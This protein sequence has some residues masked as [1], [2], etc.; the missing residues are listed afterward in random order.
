MMRLMAPP[1]PA[2]QRGVAMMLVMGA[3]TI[4]FVIAMNVL[5]GLPAT[6]QAAKNL[7]HRDSAVYLAE[8]G[9]VEALTRLA[10]PPQT[11]D[12]TGVTGRTISGMAGTYDVAITDM[13]DGVYQITS[14]GHAVGSGGG[15]VT[16]TLTMTVQVAT[17]GGGGNV[18]TM[19]HGALFGVGGFI[20]GGA[21]VRGDVF[22]PGN[23]L[24]FG[25]VD[26]ELSATGSV[27]DFGRTDS[28]SA[29]AEDVE[30]PS[31]DADLYVSY[32]YN[33]STQNA[34]T[35]TSNAASNYSGKYT[36][37]TDGN[38]L[39]VVIVEG[40]MT[41]SNDVTL[42]GGILIVRG[43]LDL[44]GHRLRINGP[45]DSTQVALI[46]EGDTE[47]S[48]RHSELEVDGG[49]TYLEGSIT[50]GWTARNSKLDARQ[51]LIVK[52]GMPLAFNGDIDVRWDN[53]GGAG[54]DVN[55]FGEGGSSGSGGSGGSRTVT[56]LSY[57]VNPGS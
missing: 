35:V 23:V 19:K 45:S 47:F 36:P 52:Q 42:E 32:T 29:R 48:S 56:P 40:D 21:R 30:V 46:V 12:W 11:G 22:V 26:G 3:V 38:A 25:R 54:T 15:A 50:S 1:R 2:A 55:F 8:S 43:N 5:S 57:S 33:G 16:H 53:N 31:I 28:I 13:G 24:N 18:Y 51:G 9:I 17:G 37:N 14:S 27:L 44:N 4:V 6:A 10:D 20:P 39:G 34:Q 49:V 7:V 41:L